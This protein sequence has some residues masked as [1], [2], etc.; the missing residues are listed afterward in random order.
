MSIFLGAPHDDAPS[1]QENENG[2]SRLPSSE[3]ASE[4]VSTLRL[5]K[6]TLILSCIIDADPESRDFLG[7]QGKPSP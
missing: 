4:S 6:H 2:N 7:S 1:Q 3:S 5:G